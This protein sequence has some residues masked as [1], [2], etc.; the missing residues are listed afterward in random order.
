MEDKN[1]LTVNQKDIQRSEPVGL[2]YFKSVDTMVEG[3]TPD[4]GKYFDILVYESGKESPQVKIL[5][6]ESYYKDN[7]VD[8]QDEIELEGRQNRLQ[9][10]AKTDANGEYVEYPREPSKF[11]MDYLTETVEKFNRLAKIDGSIITINNT[12]RLVSYKGLWLVIEGKLSSTPKLDKPQKRL[13]GN[14]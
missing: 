1:S 2:Q 5:R 10:N 14:N 9:F 7:N 3:L 12:D 4:S 11:A 8:K 6:I 13:T